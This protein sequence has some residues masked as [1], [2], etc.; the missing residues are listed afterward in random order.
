MIIRRFVSYVM[1][2]ISSQTFIFIF[3]LGK[4][5]ENTAYG[6]YILGEAI[7]LS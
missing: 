7:G 2:R 4:L 3:F 1:H 6:V 5:A